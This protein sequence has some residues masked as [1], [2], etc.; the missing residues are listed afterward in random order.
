MTAPEGFAPVE[1]VGVRV[2]MPS[3]Q[4]ILLLREPVSGLHVPIWIG[5]AEAAAIAMGLQGVTP[6][7]PLTHD[8]LW[9]VLDELGV[10]LRQVLVTELV[11]G[12]FFAVL[13]FGAGHQV[14]ARPSDAV[15]LAVRREVPVA[16]SLEVLSEAGVE[17]VEAEQNEVERFRAFLDTV[18]PEDFQ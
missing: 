2:E 14:S 15:A 5:A 18:S 11:E 13:D 8:L 4:P 16:V 12:V 9:T 10:Q 7:R 6:A 1:V 17:V 3:N